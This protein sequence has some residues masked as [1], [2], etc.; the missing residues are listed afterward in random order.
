MKSGMQTYGST[1]CW[2]LIVSGAKSQSLSRSNSPDPGG[3]K[4]RDPGSATLIPDRAQDTGA[5]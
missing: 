2:L 3:K 1:F 5:D 4:E